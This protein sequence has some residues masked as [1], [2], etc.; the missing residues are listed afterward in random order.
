MAPI[1]SVAGDLSLVS[2]NRGAVVTPGTPVSL[3]V[4]NDWAWVVIFG[5][6]K[7]LLN[8]DGIAYDPSR[9]AYCQARWDHGVKMAKEAAVVMDARIQG[10]IVQMG[11]LSGADYYSSA[12]LM[13]SGNPTRV[14]TA[15]HTLV[16]IAPP[17]GVPS[18]GGQYTVLLDV[19]R[20]APVPTAGGDFLQ[21]GPELLD[22]V[23]D[24]AQHLALFKEG[25]AQIQAAQG[26]LDRFMTMAGTEVKLEWA[27]NQSLVAV[28][29]QTP[30]D[31][32][33]VAYQTTREGTIN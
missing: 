6:L 26:L 18:G 24:Y 11:S 19:V 28:T 23:L 14:L 20:N 25:T 12:W 17:P 7:E 5:A 29:D 15:G 1:P 2:V 3:G 21:V 13:V 33:Q 31:S 27:L 8:K 30:Q 10:G 9:A 32:R 16:A 22:T 4:P